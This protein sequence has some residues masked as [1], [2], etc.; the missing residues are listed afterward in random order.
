MVYNMLSSFYLLSIACLSASYVG[1]CSSVY[2]GGNEAGSICVMMVGL[3]DLDEL[4]ILAYLSG[5]ILWVL[6]VGGALV[7]I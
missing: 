3:I 6:T 5:Y 2:C 1:Y 4:V 7:Y